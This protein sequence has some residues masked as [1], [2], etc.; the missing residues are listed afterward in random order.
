MTLTEA[1]A[2]HRAMMR[3]EL[4]FSPSQSRPPVAYTFDKV[5]RMMVPDDSPL[6]INPLTANEIT[7]PD[8]A[9]QSTQVGVPMSGR[10][11]RYL[12][13][14]TADTPWATALKSLRVHCRREHDN[15]RGADVPYWRGSLCYQLVFM[16]V[17]SKPLGN[18]PA[19]IL[20]ASQILRYDN[21]EPILRAAFDFII[22]Q[23]DHARAKAEKRE[24]ELAGHGPGAVPAPVMGHHSVPGMHM[25]DCPQ[26]RRRDAA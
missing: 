14:P 13:G 4:D 21:P 11:L 17:V 26:C 15:H 23:M 25:E 9:T 6:V 18:G 19:T 10:M 2:Q 20:E 16:T 1:I 3:D 7:V 8:S 5:R 12:Q 24:R 22:E